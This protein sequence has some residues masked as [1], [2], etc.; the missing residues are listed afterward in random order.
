MLFPEERKKLVEEVTNLLIHSRI[1]DSRRRRIL[2]ICERISI[3][4]DAGVVVAA[5]ETAYKLTRREP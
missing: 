3:E 5:I 4:N 1:A 2:P